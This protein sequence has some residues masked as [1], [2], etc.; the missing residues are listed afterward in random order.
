MPADSV[1]ARQ[2]Q[3]L[4]GNYSVLA[5]NDLGMHCGDLDTRIASIL[6]PFQVLLAQVV[7]QG[8]KPV[9]NPPGIRL[10]YSA[11]FN[12][13]DPILSQA[14][15]STGLKLDG[16]TYKTNFWETVN[17]GA[18][19]AFY[20][21]GLGLTP[22]AG[23]AFPVSPDQ[24]LPV[25]NV[26]DLYIGADGMVD[27][28]G[29]SNDGT[30]TAVQHAMPGVSNP[31]TANAP[32]TVQEH[33]SDKPFFTGFPFGYV[34]ADVNWFEAAGIPFAAFDDFGRENAYPMVRVAAKNGTTT[35]ATL[36]TV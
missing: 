23:G 9:L 6:P 7:Q 30:L 36:D 4:N 19:D 31:Y 22:L 10:E 12:T 15:A 29:G 34:A 33:Y 32:Q 5:I 1:V 21:G 20:P 14:G 2:A 35:L 13:N 27:Q 8:D 25:P 26:E 11:V 16:S 28:P 24:G 3:V 17:R 18:Y